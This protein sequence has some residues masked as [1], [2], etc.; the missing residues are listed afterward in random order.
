MAVGMGVG[1]GHTAVAGFISMVAAGGQLLS[2]YEL[3]VDGVTPLLCRP[4]VTRCFEGPA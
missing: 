1:V 3:D 4:R 2:F